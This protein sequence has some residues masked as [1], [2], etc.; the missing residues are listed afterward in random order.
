MSGD[1][2]KQLFQKQQFRHKPS[3]MV[4]QVDHDMVREKLRLP[5][6]GLFGTGLLSVILVILGTIGGLVYGGAQREQLVDNLVWQ[7][8]GVN[9]QQE[10]L[11]R[12]NLPDPKAVKEAQAKRDAQANMVLTLTIG[13]IIIGAA[14][15]CAFYCFAIA[16]GVL[17]GQLRN[18]RLCRLACILALIPVIS[19]L[20][21]AGIPFGI[22]GLTQ[23]NKPQIKKAF[24]QTAGS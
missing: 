3:D 16:A 4:Q 1:F 13:G 14:V 19:P 17:M 23:L 22:L 21:V 15:L 10:S 20:L 8:Y 9:R 5:A 11:D 12:N 2:G 18:Y 6:R 7:I 24:A